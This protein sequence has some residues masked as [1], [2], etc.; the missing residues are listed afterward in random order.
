[1]SDPPEDLPS[2]RD[3]EPARPMKAMTAGERLQYDRITASDDPF[4]IMGI[5]RNASAKEAQKA[6]KKLALWLHPDKN[7]AGVNSETFNKVGNA[8]RNVLLKL[9]TRELKK[10]M[11]GVQKAEARAKA[12]QPEKNK[13]RPQSVPTPAPV[14][15]PAPKSNRSNAGDLNKQY[16]A[17]R[18]RQRQEHVETTDRL[19]A[20]GAIL[21]AQR[22]R[23]N[24]E[25]MN[26]AEDARQ[27]R[28]RAAA[29]ARNGWTP[30]RTSASK[31]T[32]EELAEE[33]ERI[34]MRMKRRKTMTKRVV[35]MAEAAR[36][37]MAKR[38]GTDAGLE[39]H[40]HAVSRQR[41]NWL[42][43]TR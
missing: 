2:H 12:S 41:K 11:N 24:R 1:M 31:R 18:D 25:R 35:Y 33:I 6:Y 4:V 16:E 10:Q 5:G 9:E 8:Y 3:E 7:R 13:A 22:V 42:R 26:A 34:R 38:T 43:S 27:E 37:A 36:F 17:R 29:R 40:H 19:R 14:P 20:Y 15:A 28:M 23:I 21:K 32:G 30:T 39:S